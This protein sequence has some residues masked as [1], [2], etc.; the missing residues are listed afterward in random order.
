[1]KVVVA[2]ARADLVRPIFEFG[3]VDLD[4]GAARATRQVMMML[5]DDATSIERLSS[6][7]HDEV[8]LLA[9][10]EFLQQRV[11]GREGDLAAV[12]HDQGVE[13]LGTDEAL[14][15]AERAENFSA[16]GRY[17][18][19]HDHERTGPCIVLWN[20]SKYTNWNDST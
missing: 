11:H 16:L 4:R 12:A 8:N 3:S 10:H 17:T 18:R 20:D 19:T 1:M 9:G 2:V 15:P 13:L 6:I 14:H 5:V 7:G